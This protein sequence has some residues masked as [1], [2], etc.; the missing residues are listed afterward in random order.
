MKIAP[1][2]NLKKADK[3]NLMKIYPGIHFCGR[4]ES[5]ARA[6]FEADLAL[7]PPGR[8]SPGSGLRRHARPVHVLAQGAGTAGRRLCRPGDR[9]ENSLP[10]RFFGARRPRR[11]R[12][13]DQETREKMGAA[14]KALVD[15]LG[16]QRFFKVLKENGIIE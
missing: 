15:G 7:I 14:G 16:V 1:G 8:G 12:P 5:L 13:L 4:S 2:L 3:R 9:R 10:G 6:Y 11:H